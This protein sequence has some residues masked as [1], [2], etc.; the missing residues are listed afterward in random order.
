MDNEEAKKLLAQELKKYRQKSYTELQV[1]LN[2]QD[3]YAV[4][5]KSGA[6]YQIEI[7][8]FWDDQKD[9]NLRVVGAVDDGG[10]RSF[11]PLTDGF[12]LTPEGKFF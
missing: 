4:T 2:A 6:E 7:Q 10:L 5:G 11:M 8:V 1:L 3:T 9:G 12:I